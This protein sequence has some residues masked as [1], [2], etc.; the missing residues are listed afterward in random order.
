M[1]VEENIHPHLGRILERVGRNE[2]KSREVQGSGAR[3]V[4]LN[5][6]TV[7]LRNE[8]KLLIHANKLFCF[9]MLF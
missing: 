2:A 3:N 5:F 4:C 6:A 9:V 7:L 1:V 8:K